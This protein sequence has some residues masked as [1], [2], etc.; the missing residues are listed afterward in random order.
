LA[1]VSPQLTRLLLGTAFC[2]ATALGVF[3]ARHPN[4][5]AVQPWVQ[6]EEAHADDLVQLEEALARR[7]RGARDAQG[8]ALVLVVLDGWNL[9][10]APLESLQ[11]FEQGQIRA[12][13]PESLGAQ[14]CLLSGLPPHANGIFRQKGK[15]MG[16]RALVEPLPVLLQEAGWRTHAVVGERKVRPSRTGLKRG[17]DVFLGDDLRRGDEDLPYIQGDRVLQLAGALAQSPGGR[18]FLYV[19]LADG[20]VPWIPRGGFVGPG[21]LEARYLPEGGTRLRSG[22][23]DAQKALLARRES[24]EPAALETWLTARQAEWA[25]LDAQLAEFLQA[26]P[27]DAQVVVVGSVGVE[28][29][30]QME[31][32][33]AMMPQTIQ[34]PLAWKGMELGDPQRQ[35]ELAHALADLVGAQGLRRPAVQDSGVVEHHRGDLNLFIDDS[36]QVGPDGVSEGGPE[37]QARADA[38]LLGVDQDLEALR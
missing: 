1:Y 14:G 31:I 37:I 20:R 15:Q 4:R 22:G 2:T 7:F 11:G 9:D 12:C 5:V 18:Q 10:D 33:G 3:W 28:L 25:F 17:F 24:P 34:V 16:F 19:H 30:G 38:W 32:G 29:P 36:F 6:D 8:V 27:A 26:L 35:D 21:T 13:A 23:F